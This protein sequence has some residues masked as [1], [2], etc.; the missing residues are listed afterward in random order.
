MGRLFYGRRGTLVEP[1]LDKQPAP[2]QELAPAKNITK[3]HWKSADGSV[4][5]RTIEGQIHVATGLNT[6]IL[7]AVRKSVGDNHV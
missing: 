5:A 2:R 3:N 6:M 1:G 4:S 7:T